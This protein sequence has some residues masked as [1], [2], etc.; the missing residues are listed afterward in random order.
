[1]LKSELIDLFAVQP[2]FKILDITSHADDI[3]QM[4]EKQIPQDGRLSVVMYEGEHS[5]TK[6]LQSTRTQ[7][8]SSL[9]RPFRALPRDNDIVFIR[10]VLDRHTHPEKILELAY[11]TLANAATIVIISDSLKAQ[12]ALQ[13]LDRCDFRAINIVDSMQHN[14]TVVTGKKMHMWG[15]GL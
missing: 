14:L 15:K 5:F 13:M 8:I 3:T 11:T 12:I 4:L 6:T 2:G 1:M 9:S 7:S 10:D